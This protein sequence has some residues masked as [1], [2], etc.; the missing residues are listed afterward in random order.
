V[1]LDKGNDTPSDQYI[2]GFF[3]G[4]GTAYLGKQYKNGVEYPKA[5]VM[6]SQSGDLGFYLL[7]LIQEKYGGSIYEHLKAGQ[8]KATKS[9]YKLYWNKKEAV[10]FLKAILPHLVLKHQDAVNV[11]DY[12]TRNDE[13]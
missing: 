10:I 13:K 12:L 5:Q 3:D 8:H 9:A 6:L 2:A 1:I 4:E 7:N 11:I